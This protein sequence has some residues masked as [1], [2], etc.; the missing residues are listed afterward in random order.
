MAHDIVIR[1]GEIIDGSGRDRYRA[2]V[3][4]ADGRIAEIGKIAAKGREEIYAE[5][6]VVTPGFIDGHTHM[7]AQVMWDRLGASSCFHGVTTAV[8]GNCGFTLAP[9]RAS[10]R[11]LVLRNLERA[12]DISAE[13]MNQGLDWS[14]Q[15]YPEYLDA[16]ERQPLGIN[17]AS[18]IGHSAIR[19]FV[20]G[21]R[22]FTDKAT[23][24]DIRAMEQIVREAIQAGAMGFTTSRNDVHETSDDRPVASR[25]AGWDEVCRLVGV[26]GELGAGVFE[27]A[28]EG[29]QFS[30]DPERRKEYHARLSG[31]AVK[32]GVPITFGLL[33][34]DDVAWREMLGMAD[35]TVAAGGSMFVQVHSREIT[36]LRSFKASLPFDDLPVW[37]EIRALPF[38]DQRRAFADPD[39]RR[40]LA[41][42]VQ[43]ERRRD[44]ARASNDPSVKAASKAPDFQWIRIMDTPIGSHRSVAEVARE[45]NM[46]PTDLMI[47]LALKSDFNQFFQQVVLN[48][49]LDY[50]R[51]LIEHPRAV[52]T[53]SDSGAHVGT[54]MDSSLQTNLL[55]YWVRQRQAFTLED[56][57][58]RITQVPAQAWGFSDRGLLREGMK[59]DI[60]VLDP[61]TVAPAMPTIEH[62]L[63]AGAMRLKQTAVGISATLVNGSV[64]LRN[65]VHTGAYSGQ[66][67]RRGARGAQAS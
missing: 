18:Q 8:M 4:I 17:Y 64:A 52:P 31:L 51:Q 48:R 23:E 36:L 56:G 58:R 6:Q 24:D 40:R 1:G 21:E 7:D 38:A 5:G 32:T 39:M 60:N 9:A 10:A 49:N 20:M 53:F 16:V 43:D 11:E 22:A 59:A 33:A 57:I 26:M 30:E 45:R 34:N 42:A 41:Q 37:S 19:T 50:V 63:P 61:A 46:D 47:D 15:S 65:G 25:I 55:A 66:L 44:E 54:V 12:E 27:L 28:N 14:W 62:D 29:A 13:A 67:L 3:G 35:N 2:D